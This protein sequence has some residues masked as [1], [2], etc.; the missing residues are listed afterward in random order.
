[1]NKI[2]PFS[3][4]PKTW[5]NYSNYLN[6]IYEKIQSWQD[7]LKYFSPDFNILN[8]SIEVLETNS[9]LIENT[10]VTKERPDWKCLIRG[11]DN[12]IVKTTYCYFPSELKFK[13]GYLNIHYEAYLC[14]FTPPTLKIQ[15]E[16]EKVYVFEISEENWNNLVNNNKIIRFTISRV[17]FSNKWRHNG[18]QHPANPEAFDPNNYIIISKPTSA[19]YTISPKNDKIEY[20]YQKN[21]METT[22]GLVV[23]SLDLSPV[24]YILDPSSLV[25]GEGQKT[26]SL[27]AAVWSS[28]TNF[29]RASIIYNYQQGLWTGSYPIMHKLEL[30]NDNHYEELI[31]DDVFNE[32]IVN[33]LN[34]ATSVYYISST[35]ILE[36]LES[37]IYINLC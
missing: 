22:G 21:A 6:W 17:I 36:D 27:Y 23:F 28:P 5:H 13:E 1:M 31:T 26:K 10:E 16:K 3:S 14:Y 25:W 37:Q 33:S 11:A 18:A 9:L 30:K 34:H 20:T 32:E 7:Y 24:R 35:D 2:Y 8:E 12:S 15:D 4:K 29:D 19:W